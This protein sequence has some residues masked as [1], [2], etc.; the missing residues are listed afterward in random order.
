MIGTQVGGLPIELFDRQ[1]NFSRN[2]REGRDMPLYKIETV[3]AITQA[4]GGD[5]EAAVSLAIRTL[6]RGMAGVPLTLQAD[7]R[8][9]FPDA[10][11]IPG[12]TGLAGG[13]DDVDDETDDPGL[14][15][16]DANLDTAERVRR[17]KARDAAKREAAKRA[18]PIGIVFPK[19]V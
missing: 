18:S 4:M 13:H 6:G 3:S 9:P 17:K 14:A 5:P 19:R 1:G 8:S 2:V 10:K 12:D 16:F 15:D 11:R 7:R